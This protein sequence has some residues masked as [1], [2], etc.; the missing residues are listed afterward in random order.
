MFALLVKGKSRN[1]KNSINK[2]QAMQNTASD[3]ENIL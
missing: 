2:H 3:I 1:S